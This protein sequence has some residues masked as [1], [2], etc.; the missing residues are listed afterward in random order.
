[1]W[2]V[3]TGQSAM[4]L[5]WSNLEYFARCWRLLFGFYDC[6][7]LILAFDIFKLVYE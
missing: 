4:T 2:K 3:F 6:Q 5:T 7:Y 1:V